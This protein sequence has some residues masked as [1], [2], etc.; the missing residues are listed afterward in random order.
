MAS[1]FCDNNGIKLEINSRRNS[2]KLT[3]MWKLKNTHLNYYYI[4]EEIK[5]E[6]KTCLEISKMETKYMEL[7]G[8]SESNS[9]KKDLS[10]KCLYQKD[11]LIHN[12]TLHLNKLEKEP[13]KPKISIGEET[14]K[15][16]E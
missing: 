8:C 10:N 13:S 1:V 15:I 7:M 14:S 4:N 6:T 12:L 16:R 5:R 11:I 2:G 3:N 9:K